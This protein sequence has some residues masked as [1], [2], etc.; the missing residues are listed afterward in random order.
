MQF[1]SKFTPHGWATT[2]FNKLLVF[3]GDFNSVVLNM[4]VLVGFMVVFGIIAVLR[5]RTESE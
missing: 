5:F 3:G 1:I 4:L 2:A